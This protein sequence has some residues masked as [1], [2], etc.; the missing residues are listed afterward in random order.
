MGP[1]SAQKSA[2]NAFEA[3]T[4]VYHST[5]DIYGAKADLAFHSHILQPRA[6]GK[7]LSQAAL[8]CFRQESVPWQM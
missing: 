3:H 5:V 1:N 2:A 6:D 7:V 8:L 4:C